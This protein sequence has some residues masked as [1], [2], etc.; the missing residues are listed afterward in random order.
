MVKADTGG[1]EALAGEDTGGLE[2]SAGGIG[3]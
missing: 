3:T 2:A 1:L